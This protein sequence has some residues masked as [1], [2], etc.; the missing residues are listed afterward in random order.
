[1]QRVRKRNRDYLKDPGTRVN[2]EGQWEMEP[3]LWRAIHTKLKR[4]VSIV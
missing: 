3:K 1:M 2:V 4:M